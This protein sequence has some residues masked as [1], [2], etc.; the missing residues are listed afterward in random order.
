M[1]KRVFLVA[2]TIF[3]AM[4]F[5]RPAKNITANEKD[6]LKNDISSI[7]PVPE[8]VKNILKASCYDCHSNNTYYPWYSNIQPV[9]LWMQFHVDEGKL[10]LNFNEFAS[11]NKE[12]QHKKFEEIIEEIKINRMPLPSYIKMHKEAKLTQDEKYILTA[13]INS[14]QKL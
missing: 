9:G 14:L 8:N 10:E 13:W 6:N 7:Y 4:Q 1:L 3:V 12:K 11:Y 5:I 2:L